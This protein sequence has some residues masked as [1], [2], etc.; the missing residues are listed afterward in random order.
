MRARLS[1]QLRNDKCCRDEGN[2]LETHGLGRALKPL[3]DLMSEIQQSMRDGKTV[4][5][6]EEYLT[7]V[8]LWVFISFF[9]SKEKVVWV[10][11]LISACLY[12]S[13][14]KLLSL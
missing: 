3:S 14:P 6:A 11:V 1:S 8:S 4:F 9:F 5:L 12:R 2:C 7:A 10:F 13:V